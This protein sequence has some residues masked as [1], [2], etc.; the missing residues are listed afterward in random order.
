MQGPLP[1]TVD[2]FW[3]VVS[4]QNVSVIAMLTQVTEDDRVRCAIYWPRTVGETLSV[5]QE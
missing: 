5:G 1:E 3:R 2:D 4:Q